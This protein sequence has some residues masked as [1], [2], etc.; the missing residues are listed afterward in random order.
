MN[1]LQ[2]ISKKLTDKFFPLGYKKEFIDISL[3]AIPLVSNRKLKKFI[4]RL[5]Q[6]QAKLLQQDL[7]KSESD[8]S[9]DY[10]ASFLW[11][12]RRER[13]RRRLARQL[14]NQYSS[15]NKHIRPFFRYK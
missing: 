1:A 9:A 14:A 8:I 3:S 6:N 7:C 13:A 12:S 15:S 11:T 5:C 2:E 4:H 10:I